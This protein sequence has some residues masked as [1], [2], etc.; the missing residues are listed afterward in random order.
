MHACP[1]NM[2]PGVHREHVCTRDSCS[3]SHALYCAFSASLLISGQYIDDV[4]SRRTTII[5]CQ[6][7]LDE[8]IVNGIHA[9]FIIIIYQPQ[10]CACNIFSRRRFSASKC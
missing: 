10:N 1:V 6:H 8:G 3:T 2:Q 5:I 4:L 7:R 9:Y